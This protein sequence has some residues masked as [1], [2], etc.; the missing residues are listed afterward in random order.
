M[1]AV[2]AD[3]IDHGTIHELAE[4]LKDIQRSLERVGGAF[5]Q[6]ID[7]EFE[8]DK[9][10]ALL[11]ELSD[12]TDDS[13]ASERLLDTLCASIKRYEDSAPQFTKFNAE[14]AAISGVQLLKFLMQQNHLTGADLPEIGDKTVVSRTLNGKRNLSSANIQALARRF[15]LNP[16]AFY[17][18]S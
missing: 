12:S 6:Q 18:I 3:R 2:S 1:T 7:S 16:G 8:Y 14:V 4:Q 15:N 5:V 17:P 10:L 11:D 13:P 9:A